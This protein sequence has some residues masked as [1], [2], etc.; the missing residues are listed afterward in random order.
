MTARYRQLTVVAGLAVVAMALSAPQP[1]WSGQITT[2]ALRAERA[3]DQGDAATAIMN[4]DAALDILWERM[5]LHLR[6]A[7]FAENGSIEAFGRYQPRDSVFSEAGT[8]T[9][10]VEPVGYGLTEIGATFSIRL[11]TSLQIRSPGGI[12][13]AR[14]PNFGRLNWGGRTKSRE[15]HGQIVLGLPDLKPGDYEIVLGLNDLVT[16][17]AVETVLPF[18]ITRGAPATLR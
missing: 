15:V 16:G 14:A 2:N 13:Y 7:V 8:V 17:K 10:Y 18:S 5:P 12:V 9:I 1:A 6:T 4:M 3:V 11:T